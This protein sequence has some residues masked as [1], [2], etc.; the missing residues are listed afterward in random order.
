MINCFSFVFNEKGIY[1]FNNGSKKIILENI[2]IKNQK[3][4]DVKIKLMNLDSVI[5]NNN[6]IENIQTPPE[7]NTT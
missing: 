5:F 1:N 6:K 7:D 2:N 3:M 4:N